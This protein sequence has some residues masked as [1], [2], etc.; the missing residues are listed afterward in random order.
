[1]LHLP[2]ARILLSFFLGT[3]SAL[4]TA[5]T[6]VEYRFCVSCDNHRASTLISS[7]RIDLGKEWYRVKTGMVF[8]KAYNSRSCGVTDFEAARCGSDPQETLD[9][10]A[11]DGDQISALLSGN[12]VIIGQSLVEIIVGVPAQVWDWVKGW[13]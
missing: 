8:A 5:A 3:A 6:A 13:F 1:M 7:S 11:I 10:T 9:Y 2:S 12:P 4:P